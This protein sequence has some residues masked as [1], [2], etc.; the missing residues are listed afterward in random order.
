MRIALI[1][2]AATLAM[3]GACR[4]PD[5]S[6][7]NDTNA[8]ISEEN[9]PANTASASI[10]TPAGPVSKEDAA[11][12]MH[13]RHEGMEA[14]GKANK[15]IRRELDGSSPDLATVRSS[16]GKIAGLAQ[17]A[18]GWFPAGTGPDVGKTGAK[19]VIWQ[20][21][22]DFASKLKAFQSGAAAFNN[23]AAGNDVNAVKA[24]FGDLGKN[25]KACHDTYRK[26]MKH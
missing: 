23:A 22:E 19:P 1:A 11:K 6:Q 24:A 2:T 20:K 15:A 3:L 16:A 12:I 5:A 14:I 9:S 13:E 8:N 18:S 26:E 4:G 21:P 17:K 25:C 7:A 10:V